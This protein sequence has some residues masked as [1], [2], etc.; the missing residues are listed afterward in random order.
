L[1]VTN[2]NTARERNIALDAIWH[3]VHSDTGPSPRRA[4]AEGRGVR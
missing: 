4:S 2:F 3:A 1:R